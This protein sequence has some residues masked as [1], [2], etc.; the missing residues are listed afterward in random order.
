LFSASDKPVFFVQGRRTSP[1]SFIQKRAQNYIA[2]FLL[3]TT[4]DKRTRNF[5]PYSV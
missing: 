3:T 1:A 5:L 2:L 4:Y